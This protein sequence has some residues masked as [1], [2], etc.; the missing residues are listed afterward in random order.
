[1]RLELS[2]RKTLGRFAL[3]AGLSVSG[4]RIGLF[5]PS[6]SGKSTLVGAIAGLVAPDS[7]RIVLDGDVLFDRE[8]GID[9]PADRRRIAVVFQ[10]AHLFPHLDVRGNLLYGHRRAPADARRLSLE[11]V[12]EALE[13]SPLLSRSVRK[14]SGGERQRVALGRALLSNPRLLLLDEPLSALDDALRHRVIPFLR[15]TFDAFGVPFLFISHAML[16]M[17]L[18]TEQVA[19]VEAGRIVD[20]TNAEELALRRMGAGGAGYVNLLRLTDPVPRNGLSVYRWGGTEL[21]LSCDGKPGET[22]FELSARDIILIREHPGAISA[23]NLLPCRVVR[24]HAFE[25]RVGIELSCGGER[26]IAEVMRETAQALDIR[27]GQPIFAAIKA[28]AFREL[29]GRGAS[30][31]PA[32]AG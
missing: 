5:G 17:R 15:K 29:Y 22:I 32:G 26:L 19:V 25:G 3:D 10:E 1:M 27:P 13:L 31:S 16:E 11:P 14:L 6:G 12:A 7:G 23:R 9:I 4:D 18:M 20:V 8:K 30:A 21:V 28:S 2:C 24:G